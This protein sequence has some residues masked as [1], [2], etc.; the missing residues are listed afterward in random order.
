MGG[1][2]WIL[3]ELVFGLIF[4]TNKDWVAELAGFATGFLI[5]GLLQPGGWAA[6]VR[7]MRQR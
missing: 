3:G 5:S 1:P 7:T 4:G 6:L 2:D